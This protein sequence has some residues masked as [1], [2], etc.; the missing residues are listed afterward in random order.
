MT[1]K[2]FEGTAKNFTTEDVKRL[3]S[4]TQLGYKD[5]SEALKEANGDYNQALLLLQ[6][7]SLASAGKRLLKETK[8]GTV[9]VYVHKNRTGSPQLATMLE[10]CC[11]TNFVSKNLEFV[12]VAKSL[13]VHVAV[14]NPK[15]A[16]KADVP[17]EIWNKELELAKEVLRNENP[18]LEYEHLETLAKAKVEQE[19]I[20]ECQEMISSSEGSKQTV[21]EYLAS[22]IG[23]FRENIKVRRFVRF[24]IQDEI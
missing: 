2:E 11:E 15:Y 1:N 18:S 21:A 17:A 5:C 10:L 3:K 12:E 4:E 22:N 7:K 24:C 13:A 14:Q 19:L 6:A 9:A 8:E 20:L 23:V 16:Y